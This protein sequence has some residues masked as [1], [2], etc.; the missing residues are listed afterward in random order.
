[1]DRRSAAALLLLAAFLI[2]T[3]AR[4][5]TTHAPNFDFANFTLAVARFAP[6]DH[7]P[8]PPG[9]PGVILVARLFAAAGVRPVLALHLTALLGSLI[10]VLGVYLLGRRL[11]G[12]T[13]GLWAAAL[14]AFQPVFWYSGVTSPVRVFLAAGVAWLFY[15]V[16]SVRVFPVAAAVVAGFRPELPLLF[17]AP[18]LITCRR[19]GVPWTRVA[20]AAAAALVL[21]LP[22]LLWLAASF[23]SL[24][25]LLYVYYHY[26]LHH[27]SNTSALLGAPA[28]AWQA[29]L[30]DTLLWNGPV[31]LL[32]IWGRTRLPAGALAFLV[33]ALA[34]QAFFHLAP[35][36]PDHTLGTITCL[37]LAA[38][39]APVWARAAVVVLCLG[40]SLAPPGRLIPSLDILSVRSFAAGQRP[41]AYA[42]RSLRASRPGPS[43]AIVVRPDSPISHRILGPEFPETPIYLLDTTTP[44]VLHRFRQSPLA[45]ASPDLSGYRRILAPRVILKN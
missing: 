13:A 38:A 25:R 26:F 18:F 20:R 8:H 29:M 41:V 10:A 45:S 12:E 42:I 24:P 3:R 9:Y 7:Q 23:G 39:L 1:M 28:P 27:T 4:V 16:D 36:A 17:A 21:A 43:D 6:Q 30:R 19:A 40:V 33:P 2:F 31:A 22:W 34:I 44:A 14:L 15:C 5:W 37:T 11:G 35:D 32:A